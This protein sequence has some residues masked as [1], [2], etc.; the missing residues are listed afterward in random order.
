MNIGQYQ[1]IL[2][3]MTDSNL[4]SLLH[5]AQAA[6]KGFKT[7]TNADLLASDVKTL[8]AFCVEVRD[9]MDRRAEER[10]QQ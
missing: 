6:W 3:T 8:K 4:M 9:E 7:P 1:Q 5:D 2:K 10:E